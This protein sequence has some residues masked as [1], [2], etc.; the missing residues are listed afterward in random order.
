MKLKYTLD[1][2]AEELGC[3]FRRPRTGDA[4]YDIHSM[5]VATVFPGETQVIETGLRLEIPGG[6]VGIVK[7]R[8]SIAMRGVVT[9]G[10]VIDAAYR[11][12]LSVVLHNA[13]E[14]PY[15]VEPGQRVAQLILVKI[16]TPVAEM[17]EPE[18]LSETERGQDGFGSTGR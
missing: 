14:K 9:R 2:R 12:P 11:G 18:E 4:G 5:Q 7:D 10:G 3:F 1:R 16:S 8:S 6:Y 15:H 17:V 13:S